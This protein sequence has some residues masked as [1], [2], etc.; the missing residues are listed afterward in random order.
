MEGAR[1]CVGEEK[2]ERLYRLTPQ[3][4]AVGQERALEVRAEVGRNPERARLMWNVE[5]GV[6]RED[7][8]RS[9]TD[10]LTRLSVSEI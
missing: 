1:R 5:N 10:S 3:R 7:D 2:R 8:L 9:D 6:N 4:V